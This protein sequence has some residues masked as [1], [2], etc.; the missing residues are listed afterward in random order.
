MSPLGRYLRD[1]LR[2]SIEFYSREQGRNGC[3]LHDVVALSLA[4]EPAFAACEA[5]SI[6]VRTPPDEAAGRTEASPPGPGKP[7]NAVVPVGLDASA[8]RADVL[9]RLGSAAHAS[10]PPRLG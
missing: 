6:D 1:A 9:R 3:L 2:Y 8:V 7:A 4:F 10:A 5:I